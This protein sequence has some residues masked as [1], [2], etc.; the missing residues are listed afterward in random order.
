MI[1][2]RT[3]EAI[4]M[5]GYSRH[6]YGEMRMTSEAPVPPEPQPQPLVSPWPNAQDKVERLLVLMVGSEGS[7]KV[8]NSME[9]DAPPILPQD[10]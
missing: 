8:E 10:T 5:I 6:P 4:A 3:L 9:G 1:M 7:R 2:V